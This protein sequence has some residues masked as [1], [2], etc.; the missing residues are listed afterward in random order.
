MN[1]DGGMSVVGVYMGTSAPGT[2]PAD[3]TIFSTRIDF[4]PPATTGLKP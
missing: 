1:R 2:D 4:C 3:D